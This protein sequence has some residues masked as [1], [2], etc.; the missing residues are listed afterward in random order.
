VGLVDPDRIQGKKQMIDNY[1][2]CIW[3]RIKLKCLIRIELDPN[4]QP[5]YYRYPLTGTNR[6]YFVYLGNYQFDPVETVI[7]EVVRDKCRV[8]ALTEG[9]EGI[10]FLQETNFYSESGGQ[11]A[12]IGT[13]RFHIVVFIRTECAWSLEYRH[14]YRY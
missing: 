4:Q 11:I 9:E 13:I 2:A 14:R 6:T 7:C 3:I 5:C 12:D 10:V 8:S 1:F